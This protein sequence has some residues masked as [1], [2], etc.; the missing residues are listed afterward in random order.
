MIVFPHA[1]INLGLNVLE[2]RPDGFHNIESLFYPIR[3]CD[4]LEIVEN[5][6]N[7]EKKIEL[8]NSG[9]PTDCELEDNL[10]FK[11]ASSVA[12]KFDI[13][14]IKIHLHKIIPS[15]AGLGGGSSDSAFTIKLLNDLFELKMSVE[16]MKKLASELGSDC[17]YF[18]SGGAQL[19]TGVGDKLEKLSID[20]SDYYLAIIKPKVHINTAS[21][22][23]KINPSTPTEYISSIIN[24][25]VHNW[26]ENLKN[27][28]EVVV[29]G[30]NSEIEKIKLLMYE[31][32][33]LYV[34][35]TGSGSAVFGMFKEMPEL[36]ISNDDWFVWTGKM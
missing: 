34:S 25:D 20:L 35:M 29:V 26:K 7:S 17:T 3:L 13:P 33:A 22:Y 36:K 23:S 6:L 32:S 15:G 28:F 21:A 16:D 2:K 18:I 1:K 24:T 12:L 5:R 8:A 14:A 9:L 4:V 27:D 10:V 30:E 11:A 31:K 19:V